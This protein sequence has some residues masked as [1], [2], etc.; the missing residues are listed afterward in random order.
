MARADVAPAATAR[1]A[2]R[3]RRL[4]RTLVLL[5]V[6][7]AYAWHRSRPSPPPPAAP[8]P[9]APLAGRPRLVPVLGGSLRHGE[10]AD[11]PEMLLHRGR[12]VLGRDRH[13]DLRLHDLTVSPRHAVVDADGDGRV[14]LR[15]LGTRNG[16]QVDGI[17]VAEVELHDG[18]RVQLGD[19]QLVYRTDPVGDDGG[20]SGGEL[21]ENV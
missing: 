13:A 17:P 9:P 10:S 14:V 16:V 18:N 12:Q 20:R 1:P 5:G 21:G 4:P 8:T 19:V 7:G 2:R 3:R 11:P 15:D 6:A